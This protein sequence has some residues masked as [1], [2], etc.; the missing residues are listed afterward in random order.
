MSSIG[1]IGL[2]RGERALAK[3]VKTIE[4]VKP[5]R[6]RAAYT[7]KDEKGLRLVVH[8]TGNKVWFSVYQLGKGEGLK[9]KWREIGPYSSHE[10]GW[11]LAK[12]CEKNRGIQGELKFTGI[13][14]AAPKTFSELFNAWL[15]GH[16]KE[17]L[18]TWQ[19]EERRYRLHLE[20]PLGKRKV[21]DIERK[22]VR[23]IRDTV[24]E[25]AGPIQ[26]NGVVALFNRVMNWAVDE[27][28]AKFN[29]AS[30]LK[31]VGEEQR[32]ERVLSTDEMKRLWAELDRDLAVDTKLGGITFSDLPAALSVRRAIKLLFAL[33]Q[34]RGETIGMAKRELDLTADDC[35]WTIPGERTK[36]GLP[37]RVPLTKTARVVLQEALAA[38][39]DSEFVFP[40]PK[41]GGPIRADAVTKTLQRMCARKGLSIEGLGPHDIDDSRYQHA[42]TWHLRRRSRL[43]FQ[44]CVR[45]K[46][47]V[48]SWNYDAGEHDDEKR[49]SLDAWDRELRR[50]VGLDVPAQKVLQFQRA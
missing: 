18:A 24:L 35:W 31:K 19:D 50:V 47:E 3:N 26:S 29:P 1:R 45:G 8:P 36:N 28:H 33:G 44:P 38:S 48:T 13:D 30:R 9:R 10:E 46:I 37:H 39:G 41:T 34:R 11:T 14:P 12:A 23:E 27:D 20:K 7:I 43:R 42:E 2:Q 15:D 40:S 5:K 25:D 21:A 22:D 4:A 32:R 6:R 49:R 17:K 16:A